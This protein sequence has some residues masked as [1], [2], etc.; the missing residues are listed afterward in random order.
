MKRL[1]E[2]VRKGSPAEVSARLVLLQGELEQL[3]AALWQRTDMGEAA[4]V[5]PGLLRC[6]A[7]QVDIVDRSGPLP[8]EVAAGACRTAFETN[9][10]A[11]IVTSDPG[12]MLQM[13]IERLSDEKSFLNS[14]LNLLQRGVTPEDLQ[15]L[16]DRIAFLEDVQR[17]RDL[18]DVKPPRV[19]DLAREAGRLDDHRTIYGLY[20]KY[21]HAS[22][23][24]ICTEPHN[25]DDPDIR[26]LFILE[27]QVSAVDTLACIR[28]F[29]ASHQSE[30]TT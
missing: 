1:R 28:D 20:S 19:V 29:V 2:F 25:R 24:L 6:S 17:R 23:W 10:R 7:R 22:G 11:R 12:R 18:A 13:S 15:P 4:R 9:L 27:T 21:V 14:Q 8:V 16:R 30:T 26:N 3:A 5:L